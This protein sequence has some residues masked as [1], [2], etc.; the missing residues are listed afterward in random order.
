MT[1]PVATQARSCRASETTN[2]KPPIGEP[3]PP[4][5]AKPRIQL[6]GQGS[7]TSRK[8]RSRAGGSRGCP[9]R[10]VLLPLGLCHWGDGGLCNGPQEN[11]RKREREEREGGAWPG[12]SAEARGPGRLFIQANSSLTRDTSSPPRPQ[13]PNPGPHRCIPH[14]A[15]KY[16]LETTH[17][18]SRRFIG[19]QR[20]LA[21]NDGCKECRIGGL[22]IPR[23]PLPRARRLECSS[24]STIPR[25]LP[26]RTKAHQSEKRAHVE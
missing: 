7:I 5:A 26:D 4:V 25:S 12:L 13:F 20:P 14:A 19:A 24:Q 8:P 6:P 23:F 11:K 3:E 9:R 16:L 2:G 10:R 18:A 21:G 15:P 1:S 17:K 22:S